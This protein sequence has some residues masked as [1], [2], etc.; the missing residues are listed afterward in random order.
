M[1]ADWQNNLSTTEIHK[2]QI[3]KKLIKLYSD[4]NYKI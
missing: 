1:D 3:N 4:F 2:L